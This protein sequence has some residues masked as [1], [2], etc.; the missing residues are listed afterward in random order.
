MVRLLQRFGVRTAAA[1]LVL[2]MAAGV[3]SGVQAASHARLV[4]RPILL[5]DNG[6]HHDKS[7]SSNPPSSSSGGS[8]SLPQAPYAI[9]F[10]LAIVG[11]TRM[12]Y[13]KRQRQ[14]Q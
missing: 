8:T 14:S 9:F 11:V 6:H 13:Q 5:A 1:V 4:H 2:G 10:P 12:V 7:K 3:P